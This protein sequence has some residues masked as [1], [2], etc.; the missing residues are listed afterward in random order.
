MRIAVLWVLLVGGSQAFASPPAGPPD[1]SKYKSVATCEGCGRALANLDVLGGD[2]ATVLRANVSRYADLAEL[3]ITDMITRDQERALANVV[4]EAARQA[5]VKYHDQFADAGVT[6]LARLACQADDSPCV[7]GVDQALH[8][9]YG[10]CRSSNL[11]VLPVSEPHTCDPY[12]QTLKGRP[13]GL[14][15]EIATGWQD[16]KFP[17]EHRAW[18]FGLELRRRFARRLGLVARF[19]RSTGRDEGIDTNGDGRDDLATGKVTRVSILG[20]PSLMLTSGH[21]DGLWRYLELDLLG[22]YSAMTS[23][24]NEN[25]FVAGADLSYQLAVLRFGL[26]GLQGFGEA[27]DARAVLAHI[28]IVVGA[29]PG[30]SYGAGCGMT[31]PSYHSRFAL[32]MDIPLSGYELGTG[33]GYSPPFGGFGVESAYYVHPHFQALARGDLLVFLNGDEDHVL[34]HALLVGGRIDMTPVDPDRQGRTGPFITLLAGYSWGAVTK[35]SNA[36]SGPVFDASL[37]YMYQED[38]GAMWARLHGRFGM[39]PGSE[40]LRAVFLTVGLELR[41]DK[42]SWNWKKN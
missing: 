10:Q 26:R 29:W 28:G 17:N 20:G 34:H 21:Y 7:T 11:N 12:V 3:D 15:P 4:D 30:A 35:P 14:G 9:V 36:G 27:R 32:A 41:L 39:T 22:G 18:S 38:D 24:G 13:V 25:G 5:I 19:D 8:C 23:P 16:S 31:E 2:E 33:I 42:S 6:D 1:H 37:G 40:D